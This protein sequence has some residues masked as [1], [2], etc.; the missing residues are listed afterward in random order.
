MC[1]WARGGLSSCFYTYI[2]YI[3]VCMYISSYTYIK[4]VVFYIRHQLHTIY[5]LSGLCTLPVFLLLFLLFFNCSSSWRLFPFSLFTP[6]AFPHYYLASFPT[7]FLF[8]CL[9]YRTD[10]IMW[11]SHLREHLIK[12]LQ[13]PMQMDFNPARCRCHILTMIFSTPTLHKGHAYCAH[14]R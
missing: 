6:S 2:I 9:G 13:W 5:A 7:S 8:I 4:Y 1:I 10:C 11:R 12:P 3:Y 14:F